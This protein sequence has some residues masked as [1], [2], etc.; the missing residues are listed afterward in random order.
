ADGLSVER[1]AVVERHALAK[2]KTCAQRIDALPR[3]RQRRL[4]L[5]ART[6]ADQAVVDL[7]HDGVIFFSELTLR[8]ERARFVS[9]ITYHEG[10][11]GQGGPDEQQCQQNCPRSMQPVHFL[12]P[13]RACV[14]FGRPSQTARRCSPWNPT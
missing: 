4:D 11:V 1:F 8:V 9:V 13:K 3:E 2:M 14:A 6:E 7:L 5:S 10:A 12:I